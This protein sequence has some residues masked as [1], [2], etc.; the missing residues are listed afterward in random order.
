M[1]RLLLVGLALHTTSP[2]FARDRRVQLP[3]G[4]PVA[5]S[6]FVNPEPRVTN[7]QS[8]LVRRPTLAGPVG[9]NPQPLPPRNATV[10][11]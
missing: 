8:T 5:V 6:K 11:K 1:K 2:A 7:A 4:L 3:P 10:Q 9:I